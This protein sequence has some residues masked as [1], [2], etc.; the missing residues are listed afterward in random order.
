VTVTST[1]PTSNGR[2]KATR[3]R[4]TGRG[5]SGP[6]APQIC[7][8]LIA[9]DG[10]WRSAWAS[11]DHRCGAITP[12]AALAVDKQ[13]RLCLVREHASCATRLAAVSL[14]TADP[15]GEPGSPAPSPDQPEPSTQAG[16]VTRWSIVRTVPVVLDAG[17]G[18]SGGGRR[19]RHP[20]ARHVAL[21]GLLTLALGAVLL[22]R[23]PVGDGPPR[24]A[25]LSA[26]GG[27][28]NEI[29]VAGPTASTRP[30]VDPVR[31]SGPLAAPSASPPRSAGLAVTSPAP[32]STSHRVRAGDTLY[33]I[34]IHF[35]TT[36]ETL[37]Q[38]NELGDSTTI[39]IGQILELP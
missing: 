37:Q 22:A 7:P 28:S 15:S 36:V 18:T 1:G 13:R 34:A 26:T 19:T 31:S 29:A 35:G 9:E 8:Y 25:F 11:R 32:A 23:L 27:P 5:A 14:A 30:T 20:T 21:G 39:Q 38:L 17:G 16:A 2:S 3:G 10:A 12:P 33:A 24:P 4:T 6:A